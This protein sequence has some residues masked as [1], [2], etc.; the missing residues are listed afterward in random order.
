MD[1]LIDVLNMP[2]PPAELKEVK[3]LVREGERLTKQLRRF[4]KEWIAAMKKDI[5]ELKAQ[6]RKLRRLLDEM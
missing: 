2:L 3:K 6:R 5:A 4:D 1:Y